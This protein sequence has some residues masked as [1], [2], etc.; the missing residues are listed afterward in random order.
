MG[1]LSITRRA[2]RDAAVAV[3]GAAAAVTGAAYGAAAGAVDGAARGA[4]QALGGGP[5]STPAVALVVAAVG[6]AGLVDWPVLVFASGTAL[7]LRQLR[8]TPATATSTTATDNHDAVP[9]SGRADARTPPVANRAGVQPTPR[10]ASAPRKT[11]APRKASA[12][13]ATSAALAGSAGDRHVVPNP[14]GG[15]DVTAPH[16]GRASEHTDTQAEAIS[17]AQEIIRSTGGKIAIYKRDGTIRGN[18]TNSVG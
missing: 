7:V 3:T 8:H 15:W 13:R 18:D 5:R 17:R 2:G 10:K 6:A 12:P 4:S 14:E 9:S 1:L 11:S 16:A